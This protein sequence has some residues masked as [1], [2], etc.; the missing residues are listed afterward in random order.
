[1]D[2]IELT[3]TQR[4]NLQNFL[5]IVNDAKAQQRLAE[6]GINAMLAAIAEC[7][8]AAP[9]DAYRISDDGAALVKA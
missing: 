4:G 3:Q 9:D 2:R 6:Q 8:G 7:R 1:M 5:K